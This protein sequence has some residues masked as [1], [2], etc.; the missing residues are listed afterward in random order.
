MLLVRNAT[1][2]EGER[3]CHSDILE[4]AYVEELNY[5]LSLFVGEIRNKSGKPY[6]PKSIHQILCGLQRYMLDRNLTL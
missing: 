5:W 2:S 4:K 6:S 3:Q 1:V